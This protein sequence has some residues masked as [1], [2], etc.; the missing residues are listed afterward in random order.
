MGMFDEA[1]EIL[2]HCI[3]VAD[4]QDGFSGV[5][6]YKIIAACAEK[7]LDAKDIGWLDEKVLEEKLNDLRAKLI[8]RESRFGDPNLARSESIAR[9]KDRNVGNVGD[10]YTAVEDALATIAKGDY[11]NAAMIAGATALKNIGPQKLVIDVVETIEDPSSLLG[12]RKKKKHTKKDT[13]KG[14]DGLKVNGIENCGKVMT[15]CKAGGFS[16]R[17]DNIQYDADHIPAKAY[18]IERA[19]RAIEDE[20]LYEDEG[21]NKMNPCIKEAIV[22]N[23]LTVVMPKPIHNLG[24]TYGKKVETLEKAGDFKRSASEAAD[25]DIQTY[26]DVL[27]KKDAINKEGKKLTKKDKAKLKKSNDKCENQIK[28]GLD[29][30]KAEFKKPGKSPD[31]FLDQQI[32]ANAECDKKSFSGYCPKA[33]CNK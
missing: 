28:K 24:Y 13:N 31:D 21:I 2:L 7:E 4:K 27:K 20:M 22:C 33:K 3:R 11:Q 16:K 10:I 29:A 15:Y 23:A 8:T 32:K 5:K 18:M 17:G 25:R 6:K 26:K 1:D 14:R 9:M 12:S 30:I 19:R